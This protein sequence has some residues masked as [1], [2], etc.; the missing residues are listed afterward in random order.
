MSPLIYIKIFN[1]ILDNFFGFL[2]KNYS[3]QSGNLT[4]AKGSIY[5]IRGSNPRL[6][7]EQF[8]LNVG[9][10]H[11]QIFECNE[12]F[13]LNDKSVGSEFNFTDVLQL[14][15]VWLESSELQKANIWYY[16]QKLIKASQKCV[17]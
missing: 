16:L 1:D 8:A 2:E 9:V 5:V 3:S 10:Y 11:K 15:S 17:I 6:L 12:E 14:K 4:L 13:F 7:V